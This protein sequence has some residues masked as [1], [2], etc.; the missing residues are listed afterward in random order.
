MA[1]LQDL[2]KFHFMLG[3]RHGEILQLLST[4]DNIAISMRTL[5]RI[6]K[7]KGLYRM[8]NESNPQAVAS[9]LIDQLEGHGRFH[10][11]R[12]HHLCCIQAGYV[13]TQRTVRHLLKFLDPRGV[14]QRRRNRLMRRLYVNPGHN[15]M[16]HVDSS[17][18]L[19]SS[20]FL[21]RLHNILKPN[22]H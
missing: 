22:L 8:K 4:V 3:L 13:V 5:R 12:L 21:Y 2:I 18:L 15:F 17:A 6:L 1:H 14:E 10:G 16:W 9:F 7:C 20:L 19:A 11:Y